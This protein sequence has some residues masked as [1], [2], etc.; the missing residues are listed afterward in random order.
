MYSIHLSMFICLSIYLSLSPIIHIIDVFG[1]CLFIYLPLSIYMLSIFL[2]HILYISLYIC[3]PLITLYLS[4]YLAIF[5]FSFNCLYACIPSI[6]L[7]IYL[8]FIIKAICLST[9]LHNLPIYL[10]DCID[11]L[12]IHLSFRLSL[13]YVH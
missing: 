5:F 2:S 4:F 3:I 9:H 12:T 10:Y 6:D 8:S 11:C 1:C 13:Q 7:S